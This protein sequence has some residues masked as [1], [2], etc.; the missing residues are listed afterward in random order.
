MIKTDL[1][2]ANS[3]ATIT[4]NLKLWLIYAKK[5]HKVELYN[6]QLKLAKSRKSGGKK[7]KKERTKTINE[8]SY[9][10]DRY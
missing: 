2:I 6:V 3:S 1:H 10:Q 4:N 8:N 5:G 7:W 9:K